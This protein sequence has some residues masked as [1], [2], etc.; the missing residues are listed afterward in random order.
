[1]KSHNLLISGNGRIQL[2]DFGS[3]AVLR[4][5]QEGRFIVPSEF[6]A[7]VVGTIDYIAPEILLA[8]QAALVHV[9][10]PGAKSKNVDVDAKVDC[11]SLG[12]VIYEA[13]F[14]E[15]PFFAEA[16]SETY[17]RILN[18]TV[19]F[20]ES[21]LRRQLNLCC[22]DDLNNSRIVGCLAVDYQACLKPTSPGNG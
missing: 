17:D 3:A 19:S 1:M 10:S 14:G 12:V 2:T 8:H 9:H 16:V 11:W 22:L 13:L 4:P 7:C 18:Y 21:F 20:A 15:A 5:N 6:C